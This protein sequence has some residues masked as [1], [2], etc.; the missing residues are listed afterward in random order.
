MFAVRAVGAL[1]M[2]TLGPV[3]VEADAGF[4]VGHTDKSPVGMLFDEEWLLV[5]TG[6]CC[7]AAE[8]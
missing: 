1:V 5:P 7:A 8:L 4:A 2:T 3:E 6:G